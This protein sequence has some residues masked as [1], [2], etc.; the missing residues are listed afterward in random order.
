MKKIEDILIDEPMNVAERYMS[1]QI[2]YLK[3]IYEEI[4]ALR[5]DLKPETPK[6]VI[7]IKEVVK[8]EVKKVEAKQEVT[9][10]VSTRNKKGV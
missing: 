1:A 5:K 10:K 3:A 2:L 8:P 4:T 6:V 7:P 9:K